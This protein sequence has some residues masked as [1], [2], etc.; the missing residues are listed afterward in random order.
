MNYLI[1][2]TDKLTLDEKIKELNKNNDSEIVYYDLIDTS[3][4]EVLEDL[5][6]FNLFNTK[7]III[8]ENA[9]FLT[10]DKVKTNIEHNLDKLVK[11]LDNPSKDNI[12]IL[13]SSSLD[14]RKKIVK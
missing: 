12:L 14:K 9:F 2:S 6:T 4:D 11:Y 5:N 8:G 3:I 1:V 10:G 7:K 13:V